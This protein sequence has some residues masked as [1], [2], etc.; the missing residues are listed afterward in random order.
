MMKLS[1]RGSV[2]I[3]AAIMIIAICSSAP[4]V[5]DLVLGPEELV[6]AG[7][8]A[9]DVPGYSVPSFVFWDGDSLR[10]L[11]VGEGGGGLT[12]ARV[13]IYL[14]TGTAEEP[15]FSGFFY[16]QSSGSDLVGAGAG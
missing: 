12:E 3:A 10:D 8:V 6:Q 13:R 4:S 16:A 5:A 15:Q 9:I 1:H 14:N 2:T 11:V 7:G